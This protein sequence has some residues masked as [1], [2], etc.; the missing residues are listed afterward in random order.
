MENHSYACFI[1]NA[2]DDTSGMFCLIQSDQNIY[3]KI[4]I[5]CD[6][7]KGTHINGQWYCKTLLDVL[8]VLNNQY[9]IGPNFESNHFL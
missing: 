3:Y 8:D 6:D 7:N 9:I 5:I 1:K 4:N 2:C